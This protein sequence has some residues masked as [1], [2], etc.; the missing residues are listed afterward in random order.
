VRDKFNANT[1]TDYDLGYYNGGQ[2]ANY[3][4]TF[5]TNNYKVYGR[6]AGGNGPFNNTTLKLVTAGRGTTNQTT[7]LL[8]SFADANAAGWQT[9]HWVPMRDTNGNLVT[10]SLGGVQTLKA[11]SGNNLNVNFFMFATTAA[12]LVNLTVSISG[13]SISLHFPTVAGKNYTVLY[14]NTLV[15]STWQPLSPSAPGDGTVK[16][17]TDTVAGITRFY[18]LQIQ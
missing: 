8:G 6:M 5:P 3:T 10:V 14:N 7:Q 18:R 1:S 17:V 4:R 2:W 12:S 9:W 15:G 13:S 16:S 11:T